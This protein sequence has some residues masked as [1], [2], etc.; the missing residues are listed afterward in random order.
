MSCHC[1][2]SPCQCGSAPHCDS[3]N[4]SIASTLQ[5]FILMFLGSL[6]K[7]CINNQVVWILPCDLG[8]G[9][10][11]IPRNANEGLA[12]Y[13]LRVLNSLGVFPQGE[14]S[15]STSYCKGSFVSR[16]GS[17]Y[18]AISANSNTTPENNSSVWQLAVSGAYTCGI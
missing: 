3:E 11:C 17:G 8:T 13:F 4:E 18:I 6:T 9:I 15:G 16:C 5:N 7:T 2:C 12:C 14:W 1:N 10:P